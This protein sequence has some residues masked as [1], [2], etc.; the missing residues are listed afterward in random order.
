MARPL[1]VLIADDHAADAEETVAALER[2]GFAPR[3]TLAVSEAELVAA[4]ATQTPDV[5]LTEHVLPELRATRVLEVRDRLQLDVPVIVVSRTAEEPELVELVRAGAQDA[6]PKSGLLRLGTVVERE[7]RHAAQ[8]RSGRETER[9]LRDAENVYRRLIEE[10]PAL[11]Y[12][13]WAD[14]GRSLVY[15]SPQL[16]SMTGYSP[17]EWLAEPSS[18]TDRIVAADRERVLA[19]YKSA[20]ATRKPF[21][22]E[23]RILD[24]EN[25]VRWWS[26]SGR[27]MAD[28]EG[29]T[30]LVRGFVVDVSEKREAAET[31]RQL[32]HYDALTGLPNRV[33]LQEQLARVL[34][35]ALREDRKV[36]LL[37]MALDDYRE[38]RNTLGDN[39]ADQIVRELARRLGHVLGEPERVARLRGDEFA[40]ILPVA[41]ARF[42]QGVAT[43]IRKALEAPFVVEKLPIEVGM[44][45]GISV[46]PDHGE[47]AE[48][49]LRRA[50]IA[51]EAARRSGSASVV[52]SRESDPYDPQA[53]STLGELRWALEADELLLHYQPRLDLQSQQI[54]G[55]EA[56]VRWRHPRRGMVPPDRFVPLAEKGGL[57]KPLTRWVLGHA[58]AQCQRWQQQGRDLD[59]SVNLS[60][61]NLQEPEL[62]EHIGALLDERSLPARLLQLELT[63]SAVMADAAH[64]AA[65]LGRLRAG[66]VEVS[67]DDF[68]IGQSSFGYLQKLPV[69]ELKIDKSFVKDMTTVAQDAAIVRST[70]QLGH[71]L[72]LKVVAE[73]VESQGTL[74]VLAALGCDGAQGYYIARPMPSAEFDEWLSKSAWEVRAC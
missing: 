25:R 15:V 30:R 37:F 33:L 63:E 12:I 16:R 21:A 36:A 28:A 72:G 70:N 50:D 54:V 69:S 68:G 52:Y 4:L 8:R 61:R 41:D 10:I 56:L 59:V 7:L 40:A 27:P 32:S 51:L 64:A 62:V 6:M 26:D 23:Y 46:G 1:R 48:V 73:G 31:I 9:Q 14:E 20:C 45:I 55:A 22:S 71:N 74:D 65:V 60:A 49:L 47:S 13:S 42:A 11:T 2:S 17:A 39:A 24:A 29:R 34:A 57:I 43:T 3:Y 18:W 58:V 44:S 66:G 19:E 53:L 67:I 5:I 38:I 35:S